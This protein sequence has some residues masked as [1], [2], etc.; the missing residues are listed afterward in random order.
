MRMSSKEIAIV[1]IMLGLS[2]MLEVI[3]VEM[4]TMWGMKI[5][6]VA[7]PI[8]MVYLMTGFLGGLTA[9]FL[10][11]IGLSLVSPSSWLGGFMKASA[12]LTVLLGFEAARWITRFDFERANRRSV[13]LFG[14]LAYIFGVAIRIPLMVAF[15]YYFAIQM[16]LGIP[17]E[18]VVQAVEEWTHVPFW[19]AIGL[20]NAVQSIIDVFVSLAVTLPV[21]R[22]L[23]HLMG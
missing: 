16:F 17:H 8:V 15:N 18:R 11:F 20:P 19:V 4:P 9:V 12:T 23:P 3:P 7:V 13:V 14:V 2:L 10:L 6:L 22:R 5:D 1:G 21:L